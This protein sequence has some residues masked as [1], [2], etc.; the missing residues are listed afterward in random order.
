MFAL[1]VPG[2]P[3]LPP[4]PLPPPFDD[5]LNPPSSA[6][7]VGLGMVG[8]PARALGSRN[9]LQQSI[10][11]RMDNTRVLG[12]GAWGTVY[13]GLNEET[14]ELFAIKEVRFNTE[15]QVQQ[16]AQEIRVMKKLDHPNIV[17][18]FGGERSETTLRIFMEYIPGGSLASLI[19]KFGPL[20]EA[21]AQGY[22]A[23]VVEGLIYLHSKNIAHRDIKCD[24]MLV[25]TNG[26][27]KLADFGQSKEAFLMRT[28]TGTVCFMAPEVMRGEAYTLLADIWS[29]GCAVIE[30]LSGRP[31]FSRFANQN[32]IMYNID[33]VDPLQEIPSECTP[34]ARDHLT[35]CLQRHPTER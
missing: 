33:R 13:V 17:K 25:Q 35:R 29:Y 23:D 31:P 26:V 4:P 8:N 18:Y 32:A 10:H 22:S 28:V 16:A 30:M 12:R 24:N 9:P 6:G 5:D 11:V 15:S 7:S 34:R 20:T 3:A 19:A 21:M 1:D 2:G 14:R 27:V